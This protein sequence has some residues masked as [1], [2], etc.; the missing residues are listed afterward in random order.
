MSVAK[1]SLV[2]NVP[3]FEAAKK[4]WLSN[5]DPLLKEIPK[6]EKVRC[7]LSERAARVLETAVL[8]TVIIC[9]MALLSIPSIIG[10]ATHQ[11]SVTYIKLHTR[12]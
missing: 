4:K 12:Q 11:V 6:K 9:A 5:G 1:A 7:A 8:T 2:I 3:N 10:F